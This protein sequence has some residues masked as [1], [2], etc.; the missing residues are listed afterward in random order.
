MALEKGFKKIRG[1]LLAARANRVKAARPGM[2]EKPAHDSNISHSLSDSDA[3]KSSGVESYINENKY[4]SE[5]LASSIIKCKD[6]SINDSLRVFSHR[7]QRI[8]NPDTVMDD[9]VRRLY[10]AFVRCLSAS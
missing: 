8:R 4:Y 6:F 1:V 10:Q 5:D 9:E 7:Q 2:E 3:F